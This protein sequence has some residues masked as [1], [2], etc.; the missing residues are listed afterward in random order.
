MTAT[1][2]LELV[3]PKIRRRQVARQQTMFFDPPRRQ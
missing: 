1:L 2:L 3:A